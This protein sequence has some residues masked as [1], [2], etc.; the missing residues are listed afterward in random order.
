MDIVKGTK[1]DTAFPDGEVIEE[2]CIALESPDEDGNFVGLDSE[3]I[4]V[5]FNTVMVKGF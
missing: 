1:F 3:G 2:G 5:E 4:R